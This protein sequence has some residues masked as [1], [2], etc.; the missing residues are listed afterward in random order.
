[1]VDKSIR[2]YVPLVL[3]LIWVALIFGVLLGS[4]DQNITFYNL[5][6]DYMTYD[7]TNEEL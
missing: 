6:K 1:M 7:I 3:R 4:I 5:L 2:A